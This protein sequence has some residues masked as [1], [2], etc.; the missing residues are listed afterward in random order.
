MEILGVVFIGIRATCQNGRQNKADKTANKKNDCQNDQLIPPL[1]I[2]RPLGQDCR[3]KREATLFN[4]PH[5]VLAEIVPTTY[6]IVKK[7]LHFAE[8]N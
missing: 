2:T 7:K 1:L 5:I 6:R 8:K 4:G 3:R